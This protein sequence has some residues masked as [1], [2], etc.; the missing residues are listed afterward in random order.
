[1]TQS[2]YLHKFCARTYT[3]ICSLTCFPPS[4]SQRLTLIPEYTLTQTGVPCQKQ[5]VFP[6]GSLSAELTF[7]PRDVDT[8]MVG[9]GQKFSHS[10]PG[11]F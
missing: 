5:R 11:I 3:C 2:R 7:I 10:C 9:H 8:V 1:M 4:L 6:F